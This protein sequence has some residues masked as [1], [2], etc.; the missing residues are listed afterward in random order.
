MATAGAQPPLEH[1]QVAHPSP[2]AEEF[3]LELQCPRASPRAADPASQ[4]QNGPR[5]AMRRIDTATASL[6]P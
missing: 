6:I 4:S 1:L 2:Q 5:G 3:L